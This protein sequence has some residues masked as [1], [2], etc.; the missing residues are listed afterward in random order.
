MSRSCIFRVIPL[1]FTLL[2]NGILAFFTTG[3]VQSAY[4]EDE[5][6]T[7]VLPDINGEPF[8]LIGLDLHLATPDAVES[9]QASSF[10]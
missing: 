3:M 10:H 7:I 9:Y 4:S 1:I 8:E 5:E 2:L 6:L